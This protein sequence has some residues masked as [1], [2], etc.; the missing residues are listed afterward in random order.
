MKQS[1]KIYSVLL[2]LMESGSLQNQKLSSQADLPQ[3]LHRQ[4]QNREKWRLQLYNS[5]GE[6]E[7]IKELTFLTKLTKSKIFIEISEERVKN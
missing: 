7:N 3:N 2:G 4:K 1:T 6:W 5:G